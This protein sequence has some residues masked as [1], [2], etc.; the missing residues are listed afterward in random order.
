VNHHTSPDDFTAELVERTVVVTWPDNERGGATPPPDGWTERA[1]DQPTLHEIDEGSVSGCSALRWRNDLRPDAELVAVSLA[2]V[3]GAE[4]PASS[5]VRP[6][7]TDRTALREAVARAIFGA[8]SIGIDVWDHADA[9]TKAVVREE[10]DAVLARLPEPADRAALVAERDALGR[11]AD[12]LR[13]DWVE[14]RTRAERAEADRAAVIA[15]TARACAKHLR[16]NWTD[17]R[18]ADA[19]NSLDLN[20]ARIER[21]EDTALLRHLAAEC[22]QCG[23]AGACNGGPCPLP[24]APAAVVSGRAADETQAETRDRAAVYREVAE[25]LMAKYGVTNRA[26][27][28]IRQWATEEPSTDR[29]AVGGAQPRSRAARFLDALTHSGPGYDLTTPADGGAQQPKEAERVIE[30]YCDGFPTT[31]PNPVTVAPAP[32]H[33]DGGIRCGCYDEPTEAA[34]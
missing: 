29:P 27:A 30:P 22:S 6:P 19:A 10:A 1:W 24:A 14:M 32:P 16:F 12:R 23:D 8:H 17:A 34:R 26:A 21:G 18:T 9:H 4:L 28:Q 25:R 31:C 5:A 13:K 11:E 20:A 2:L 15:A 3:S 7:A 33:H